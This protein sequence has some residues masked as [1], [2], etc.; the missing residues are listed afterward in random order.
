[1]EV[2]K[3][4]QKKYKGKTGYNMSLSSTFYKIFKHN[5]NQ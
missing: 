3:D 2:I 4:I 1:M 5:L